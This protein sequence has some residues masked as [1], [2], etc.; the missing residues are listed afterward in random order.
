[1][2]QDEAVQQAE[3]RLKVAEHEVDMSR[4]EMERRRKEMDESIA[5]YKRSE[6]HLS[7]MWEGVHEAR[8]AISRAQSKNWDQQK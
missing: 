1:M 3:N 7:K 5:A 4:T 6:A 8:I 2:T